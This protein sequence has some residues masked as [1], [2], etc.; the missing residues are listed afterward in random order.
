VTRCVK[1]TFFVTEADQKLHF[2]RKV[3]LILFVNKY[4]F[5]YFGTSRR[6]RRSNT[7]RPH[8]DDLKSQSAR[9]KP[10]DEVQQKSVGVF[11]VS[12]AGPLT[13]LSFWFANSLISASRISG[14]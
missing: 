3:F 2:V 10:G 8:C 1:P 13:G 14:A 9:G 6:A 12:G 11:P 5:Q 4:H 7:I